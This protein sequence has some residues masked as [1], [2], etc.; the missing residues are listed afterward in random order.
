MDNKTV[1]VFGASGR[2]GLAQIRQLRAQGYWVR[3]VSRSPER[4]Y[5]REFEGVAVVQAD[6]NDLNSLVKACDNADAVFFTH[7]MFEDA[8]HVNDHIARVGEAAKIVGVKR[9]V[10]NTSSW[11]PDTPCGEPNYDGNLIRENIFAAC[12]VP[13]TVIRPVLFMDN[14]LTNWVKPALVN[15][16]VYRYPHQPTMRANWI[17]LDDVAKFMIAAIQREDLIGERIIIG[18]PDALL[19]DEVA[20]HLSQAFGKTISFE[21]ITPRHYGEFM[22][23]VFGDVSPLDRESYAAALDDFYQ[24]NN[25]TNGRAFLVDM[26]PVLK[27]IPIKLTSMAEWAKQQDWVLRDNGPSGG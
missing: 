21:Y 13:L 16:G 27:R 26:Q 8:L 24:Y 6:Y 20:S 10:Y 1:T 25:K 15:E 4:F 23:D 2:Q 11:V 12:G 3:A 19:P 5:T 9:L 7:P 22:H 17:C 14:L 18:G